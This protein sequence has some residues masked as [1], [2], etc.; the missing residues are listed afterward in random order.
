MARSQ[1]RWKMILGVNVGIVSGAVWH[2]TNNSHYSTLLSGHNLQGW[3]KTGVNIICQSAQV[4]VVVAHCRSNRQNILTEFLVVPRVSL[5]SFTTDAGERHLVNDDL[6]HLKVKCEADLTPVVCDCT[7][8]CVAAATTTTH[9]SKHQSFFSF[10]CKTCVL[11]FYSFSFLYSFTLL[12][13]ALLY[14]FF[15]VKEQ[16]QVNRN[17]SPNLVSHCVLL[18]AASPGS[19]VSKAFYVVESRQQA[20]QIERTFCTGHMIVHWLNRYHSILQ[21]SINKMKQKLCPTQPG[22]MG[23]SS[24]QW[25]IVNTA[26]V[27]RQNDNMYWTHCAL[28]GHIIINSI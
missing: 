16:W 23:F 25:P 13:K 19:T 14:C 17:L 11:V 6:H 12:L 27:H 5:H 26:A 15:F 24:V 18:N 9:Q 10:Q 21:L 3:S 28:P 4:D 7:A 1:R 20:V 8:Q 2:V 22:G